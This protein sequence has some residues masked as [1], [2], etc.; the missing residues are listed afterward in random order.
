MFT[1]KITDLLYRFFQSSFS[2]KN[3]YI[4][5][6]LFFLSISVYY[7][8]LY[9]RSQR[10]VFLFDL[11]FER[12]QSSQEF[13]VFDE[14]GNCQIST[15][16]SLYPNKKTFFRVLM[17]RVSPSSDTVYL[18]K[19]VDHHYAHSVLLSSEG[20]AWDQDPQFWLVESLPIP[21]PSNKSWLVVRVD[22]LTKHFHP[23]Y[24]LQHQKEQL[25]NFL[26]NAPFGLI[27][28]NMSKNIVGLN[29]TLSEWVGEKKETLLGHPI[30][31]LITPFPDELKDKFFKVELVL[32]DQKKIPALLFPS[33][34]AN[35]SKNYGSIFSSFLLFRTELTDQDSSE[36]KFHKSVE[37]SFASS[38]IPTLIIDHGGMILSQNNAFQ[39]FINL[40]KQVG[41]I[42]DVVSTVDHVIL[43]KK[44]KEVF[45][46]KTNLHPFE[47]GVHLKHTMT[48]L[49]CLPEVSSFP[50]IMIQLI[51]IS[52][53]KNLEQQFIQSQKMQAVGQLAGGIAHDFNNLLTAMI[54]F[55]D[56]LLQRYI[57]SDPAYTDVMQIKQ[58]A[59]RAANLVKQLLAFSRKQTLHPRI[60]DISEI[61]SEL[62]A[63]LRRL[64][65][66]NVE[67]KVV[68]GRDV[69]PIKADPSQLEQVIVNLAVNARDAM[70]KGG[71]LH[72]HTENY[73]TAIH[74]NMGYDLI[75]PGEYVRIEVNDDG[76]GIPP[77]NIQRIFE[78][79]FSTK[80]LTA[81]TGLGL[82][83][84]YG[85]VKQTG[86]FIGIQSTVD[87]GTTFYIFFPRE[88]VD[89]Q[90]LPQKEVKKKIQDLSGKGIILLV[91][92]DDAVRLFGARALRD[93]GYEVLE[94]PGG[95]KALE[96][97]HAHEHIDLLITDVMMPKMDGPTLW[98]KIRILD[99]SIRTIFISGYTEETFRTNTGD[100]PSVEFLS[101]PFNMKDLA[102]KVKEVLEQH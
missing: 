85:I 78:P 38:S 9:R 6:A 96:L 70:P 10:K 34:G 66:V 44:I 90:L 11:F 7:F 46:Q 16:P 100:G 20:K 49:S 35:L 2:Q 53:Q 57:P 45:R 25:E 30:Q 42:F 59:H 54:G 4:G 48:Y 97:F 13:S 84:V 102:E 17:S 47:M 15:H 60:V 24:L 88:Y 76:V 99:P 93:K 72:I 5:L 22:N 40:G 27:Y 58:N 50:K 33:L 75:P 82:P 41:S 3:V 43:S 80:D 69:W 77:E 98:N 56:L 63:L 21:M 12:L 74:K 95:E 91:E 26:D 73:T 89:P 92:D 1:K 32:S 36:P 19:A 14:H 64:I 67:L 68:H 61:L 31:N 51:D 39:D 52:D 29:T 55:C 23:Y 101:K 87:K 65:G 86:G 81:G 79:F 71:T 83:T 94:A 18:Q 28:I 62:S 8:I 37:A